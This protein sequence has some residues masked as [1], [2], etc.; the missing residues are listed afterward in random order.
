M[1]ITE[2]IRIRI[3]HAAAFLLGI[4]W[5]R[6]LF[7]PEDWPLLQQVHAYWPAVALALELG[8]RKF[9]RPL[10]GGLMLLGMAWGCVRFQSLQ[11]AMNVPGKEVHRAQCLE[12]LNQSKMT[13]LVR[14]EGLETPLRVRLKHGRLNPGVLFDVNAQQIK[15]LVCR[16]HEPGQFCYAR[17]SLDHGQAFGIYLDSVPP[18]LG[19]KELPLL[20]R[21]RE[22]VKRRLSRRTSLAVRPWALA[23][24]LGDK[25]QFAEKEI[26]QVQDFGL[27]H[28]LAISG[29]HIGLFYLCLSGAL[30]LLPL[31][32]T[33]MR[34]GQIVLL[35]FVWAYAALCH[36]VPSVLRASLFITWSVWGRFFLRCPTDSQ[37]VWPV[38]LLMQ[39][40]I[41]PQDAFDMGFQLSYM[42]TAAL[43]YWVPQAEF[44][45]HGLKMVYI[46]MVCALLSFPVLIF[47]NGHF[48]L[49]FWV[50]ALCLAPALVPVIP[51]FW[52][53]VFLPPGIWPFEDFLMQ[54]FLYF[55]TR[56]PVP[57]LC[58]W[59]LTSMSV[60]EVWVLQLS[61]VYFIV[62][63]T[64]LF[65]KSNA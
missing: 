16:G 21:C 11:A 33:R 29:L 28:V 37:S 54:V 5:A 18:I 12:P 2:T 31:S 59:W 46:T 43:F 64:K 9:G 8:F 30:R 56:I 57:L 14:I 36:M 47:A 6:S 58:Y 34:W 48:S 62:W 23:L 63:L 26:K 65:S 53:G 13:Y 44:R 60:Y 27:M 55:W 35:V 1:P 32:L 17:W 4:C 25:G 10:I 42:A 51:V 45:I 41:R 52:I 39:L 40:L 3:L 61:L 50:G 20:Y 22:A 49:G 38:A 19:T 7:Y 15:P 24:V